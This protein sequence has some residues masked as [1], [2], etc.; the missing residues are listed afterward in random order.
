MSLRTFNNVED[1]VGAQRRGRPLLVSR[2]LSQRRLTLT[3]TLEGESDPDTN[4]REAFLALGDR[5]AGVRNGGQLLLRVWP[6]RTD[7]DGVE[8]EGFW[9]PCPGCSSLRDM[10]GL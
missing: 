6:G 9:E 2:R 5:S 1:S 3:R 10:E 7:A 4:R 8:Q